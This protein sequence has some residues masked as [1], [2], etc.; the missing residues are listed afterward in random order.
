MRAIDRSVKR[1]ELGLSAPPPVTDETDLPA[2][3][4]GPSPTSPSPVA[5]TE[6][7]R[8][9]FIRSEFATSLWNAV[10]QGKSVTIAARQ[11][12]AGKSTPLTSLIPAI[13]S[14]RRSYVIRGTCESFEIW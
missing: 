5:L 3:W 10:G 12:G 11:S 6:L 4:W 1:T 2:W 8:S 13:A 14:T 9:G 7:M